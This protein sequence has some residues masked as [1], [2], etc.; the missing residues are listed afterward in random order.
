MR[1]TTK[2]KRRIFNAISFVFWLAIYLML[3]KVRFKWE[4]NP[5]LVSII[6]TGLII[7]VFI[8]QGRL[9]KIKKKRLEIKSN[10]I[11]GL[12]KDNQLILDKTQLPTELSSLKVLFEKW[13]IQND[14]LREDL[15]ENTSR[16]ELLEFKNEIEP[17]L[18]QIENYLKNEQKTSEY[19]A[20]LLTHKAYGDL[21]LWTW[22]QE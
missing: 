10:N 12:K 17:F 2:N 22:G 18:N 5:I 7:H 16:E 14:L 19:Q 15:Y 4:E 20:I 13:G 6:I 1:I 9:S 21:G 8:Y 3:R 11:S